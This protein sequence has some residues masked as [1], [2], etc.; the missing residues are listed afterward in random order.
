MK[1]MIPAELM[2]SIISFLG[3]TGLAAILGRLVHHAHKAQQLERKFFSKHLLFELIIALG[4]GFFA[5]GLMEYFEFS[6]KVKI[7]GIIVLSYLG[8]SGIEYYLV[9]YFGSSDRSDQ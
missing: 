6:G 7:A 2:Q 5:D 3:T 4:I 1:E 8:P 9:K